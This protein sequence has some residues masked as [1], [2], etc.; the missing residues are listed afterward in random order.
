MLDPN[1]DLVLAFHE[2]LSKSK[3][4]IDTICEAN[5]RGIP[6]DLRGSG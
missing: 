4:T 1:E 2:D 6:V 5:R 3:G